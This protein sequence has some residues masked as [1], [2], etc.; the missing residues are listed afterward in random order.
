MPFIFVNWKEFHSEVGL[1]L[2]KMPSI[3]YYGL[4]L[5]GRECCSAKLAHLNG[6]VHTDTYIYT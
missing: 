6:D 4:P 5:K 3:Y 2:A 1:T